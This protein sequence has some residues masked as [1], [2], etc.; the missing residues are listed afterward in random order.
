M[1]KA[2]KKATP[3]PKQLPN[4]EPVKLNMSFEEA[5]KRAVNTPIKNKKKYNA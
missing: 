4:D 2:K 5:I 1:A 3:K